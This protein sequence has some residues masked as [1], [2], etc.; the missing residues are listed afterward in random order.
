MVLF[1][2]RNNSIPVIR[3]MWADLLWKPY[4]DYFIFQQMFTAKS[5]N[6]FATSSS[7]NLLL[8]ITAKITMKLGLFFSF[9]MYLLRWNSNTT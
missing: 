6:F 5:S 2:D 1:M 9:I 4:T 3:A 7:K 8:Y